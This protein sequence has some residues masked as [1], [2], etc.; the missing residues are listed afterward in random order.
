VPA[1]ETLPKLSGFRH[2]IGLTLD[3][4]RALFRIFTVSTVGLVQHRAVISATAELLLYSLTF[5][6]I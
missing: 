5:F 4:E 3:R 1:T 6:D 2:H